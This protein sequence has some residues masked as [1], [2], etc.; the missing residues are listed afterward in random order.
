[1]RSNIARTWVSGRVPEAGRSPLL[2]LRTSLL[3]ALEGRY[4]LDELVELLGLLFLQGPE[5][6]HRWRGIDQRPG[7]RVLAEA[8]ADLRQVGTERVAVLADLVAAQAARRG[9]DLFAL[10]VLR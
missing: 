9:G 5:R 2:R 10:L 8:L 4:V 1:M 6:R 7:D 3:V